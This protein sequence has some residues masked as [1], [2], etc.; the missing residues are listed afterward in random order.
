MQTDL[1]GTSRPARAATGPSADLAAVAAAARRGTEEKEDPLEA[2]L[3]VDQPA[4]GDRFDLILAV[5]LTTCTAFWGD[6]FG[7]GP[8]RPDYLASVVTSIGFALPLVWRR[9]RPLLMVAAMSLCGA[10][11]TWLVSV[12]T[13]SLVAFPLASYSVARKVN[14]HHSRWVLVT[15][16]IGSVV[17]PLRWLSHDYGFSPASTDFQQSFASLAALCLAWVVIPYLLGRRD[18][19]AELARQ[20]RLRSARERHLAELERREQQAR[21][22]EVRVRNEIARELHDVVAHSLSVIIVQAD[23]GKAL[24]R[25]KPEAAADVLGTI[26]QTGRDALGEMR[27]IVGILRSDPDS[28]EPAQYR[29]APGLD[30]IPELVA[31]AGDRVQL[32]V[33]G[34]PPPAPPALGVTAYRVVQESLTNFMKHAGPDAHATVALCYQPTGVVIEVANDLPGW[35]EDSEQIAAVGHGYGLQGMQERVSAMGGN[36]TAGT[37]PNRGWLV[38]AWLPLEKGGGVPADPGMFDNGTTFKQNSETA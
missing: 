24:A 23:G 10:L 28:D 38:R 4:G 18:R 27:R 26:S 25:K 19:E 34:Q 1:R 30:D 16:T 21:V 2:V 17:G 3:A 9:R 11:Q 15:G 14:S 36:L 31:H 7:N 32:S 20:E 35:P 5:V 33:A 37:V 13:W 12:P 6:L 8:S 22:A 29:P